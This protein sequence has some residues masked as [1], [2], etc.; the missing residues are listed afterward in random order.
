MT[1]VGRPEYPALPGVPPGERERLRSR[2]AAWEESYVV[3]TDAPTGTRGEI[4][5]A[6]RARGAELPPV[7]ATCGALRWYEGSVL[8][9]E[10]RG[11]W[12]L[13]AQT[14]EQ[15][16]P[17]L[18]AF[19]ERRHRQPVS[20]PAHSAVLAEHEPADGER[21][22]FE[23]RISSADGD[24]VVR[25]DGATL[26]YRLPGGGMRQELRKR[27]EVG[28]YVPWAS[29]FREVPVEPRFVVVDDEACAPFLRWFGAQELPSSLVDVVSEALRHAHGI[30]RFDRTDMC[31]PVLCHAQFFAG[32]SAAQAFESPLLCPGDW[33]VSSNE[34]ARLLVGYWD[35]GASDAFVYLG[36]DGRIYRYTFDD[37]QWVV[38]A[39][40]YAAYVE[41]ILRFDARGAA[42]LT[43]ELPMAELRSRLELVA[44]P[45]GTDA[46]GALAVS[47]DTVAFQRPGERALLKCFTPEA[48]AR[49]RA[50]LAR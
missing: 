6:A 29:S 17:W 10:S 30:R 8:V 24:V 12:C 16:V 45:V 1:R 18:R 31:G 47:A 43:S 36:A 34:P 2:F 50:R 23:D 4:L 42:T 26:R 27:A 20:F 44:D 37:D 39:S 38:S 7:A 22:I 32:V 3:C 33:G 28:L 48:E 15:L 46:W 13:Y 19:S 49:G 21:V 35:L 41:R 25:N 11:T 5:G 40:S 14:A 9:T